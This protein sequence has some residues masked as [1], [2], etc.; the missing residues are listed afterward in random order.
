MICPYCG[1]ENVDRSPFCASCGKSLAGTYEGN[2]K[3]EVK[4]ETSGEV[5]AVNAQATA[6]PDAAPQTTAQAQPQASDQVA[7]QAASQPQP[8]ATAHQQAA[9]QPQPQPQPVYQQVPQPVQPQSAA[10][11]YAKGCFGAAWS[12]IT[13]TAGWFKKMLLL[14][15]IMC[16]PVLNFYVFGY[17]MRWARQ[18]VLGK[19]EP[20][21][22]KIFEEGNF[23]QGF[24]SM[25]WL[26]V[27]GIVVALV[28]GILGLVPLL[29]ALVIIAL[30]L[31]EV[32]FGAIGVLRIAISKR[33]GEGFSLQEDWRAMWKN[34]GSLFC[35]AVV[36]DLIIGAIIFVLIMIATVIAMVA[37]FGTGITVAYS[38]GYSSFESVMQVIMALFS[39]APLFLAVFYIYGVFYAFAYV[40]SFRAVGHYV[41]RELPEW[42]ALAPQYE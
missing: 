3:N 41:A 13:S 38:S 11:V 25:V 29:G 4:A 8:Q 26:L 17:A 24:Y 33:I 20:M 10:P 37:L 28:N 19:I 16:V 27:L 35:A 15:L 30:S 39:L 2:V 34:F 22:E 40:W 5:N 21:P 36:P 7:A 1:K 14:G 12:D 42:A 18:L 9:A 31:F 32:M 6:H 23:S